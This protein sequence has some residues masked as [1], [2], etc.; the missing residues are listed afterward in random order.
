ME[1]AVPSFV[2]TPG[3]KLGARTRRP[4]ASIMPYPDG[5]S[6]ID[7]EG[8][9]NETLSCTFLCGFIIGVLLRRSAYS[10]AGRGDH[11]GPFGQIPHAEKHRADERR[12]AQTGRG[13]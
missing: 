2:F 9:V 3:R 8:G 1:L 11:A 10:G 5:H 4:C 6:F 13:A 7:L 12:N